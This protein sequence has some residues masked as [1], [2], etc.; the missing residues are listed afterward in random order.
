VCAATRQCINND[1]DYNNRI[2]CEATEAPW[3]DQNERLMND[4]HDK[5]HDT[6]GEDDDH[7]RDYLRSVLAAAAYNNSSR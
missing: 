2:T 6:D 4:N 1:D 5:S 7:G 3:E